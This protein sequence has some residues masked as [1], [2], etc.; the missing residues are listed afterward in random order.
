MTEPAKTPA[1]APG[2]KR[3][4]H[5]TPYSDRV[6]ELLRDFDQ[7]VFYVNRSASN[8]VGLDRTLKNFFYVSLVDSWDH[9]NPNA[10]TPS[11]A[12]VIEVGDFDQTIHWLLRNREVQEFIRLNTPEGK[13]PF[14]A[15]MRFSRETEAICRELG[16]EIIMPSADLRT[17]LDSKI[18]TTELGN[19]VGVPSAPNI[20]TTVS[21]YAELTAAAE[22][23]GLGES[24]VIQLPYGD[25]GAT[26]YFVENADDWDAIADHVSGTEIKVMKNIRHLPLATEAVVMDHGTV[27]GSTLRE[28][29]GHPELTRREGGWTGSELYP[30]MLT[31]EVQQAV[32]DQ[33]HR[34]CE[35]V[36]REG[37]RGVLE[38]S[39]LLDLDTNAVYLGELNPRLSGSAT[40]SNL[41]AYGAIVPLFAYH[42]LQFAGVPLTAEEIDGVNRERHEAFHGQTWSSLLIQH[43]EH[44]HKLLTQVPKSG[45]YR[46]TEEGL[47]EPV[48][49]DNDWLDM[50]DENEVYVLPGAVVGGEV[51]IGSFLC[52]LV[53][54]KRMQ[55]DHYA[56]SDDARTLIRAA[57]KLFRVRPQSAVDRYTKKA[58]RIVRR[59]IDQRRRLK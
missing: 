15:L 8:T 1:P 47:L 26:T 34:F 32:H 28:I 18:V 12:P 50:R 55:E 29:T 19:S 42:V 11:N 4:R 58:L 9:R 39:T 14:I 43:S 10:F 25:S 27:L 57:K 44:N 49:R 51:G 53:S 40:H 41:T 23:A 5:T 37:Y 20:L 13:R 46:L 22:A 31:D 21:G 16:Y 48:S 38:V 7:P 30:G 3:A 17:R 56:L 6:R 45:R 36:R 52:M 54:H 24:L 33:V 35:A 59:E 2:S